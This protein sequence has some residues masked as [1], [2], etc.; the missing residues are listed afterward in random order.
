MRSCIT[1]WRSTLPRRAPGSFRDL[2][3]DLERQA[4][5]G[6]VRKALVRFC[7]DFPPQAVY[8]ERVPLDEYLLGTTQGVTNREMVLEE[9]LLLWLANVNP[10]FSPFREL[11]D[12]GALAQETAY[13]ELMAAA[14]EF[15]SR[16]PPFGPDGQSLVDMLRAPALALPDSLSG[17][18][19]YI[20]E[21]WGLLLGRVPDRLLSGLDLIREE[22][23]TFFPGPGPPRFL[24]RRR[25]QAGGAEKTG[26][27]PPDRDWMPRLVLMAKN[28]YVWLDQLSAR[29]TAA[30]SPPWTRSRTRN[31]TSWPPGASPACG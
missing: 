30:P 19:Q 9:M 4:G 26:A 15:F 29:R 28:I 27:L 10:A 5:P 3:A 11:F 14:G 7:R 23:K 21:H 1:W 22:E 17:Q 18:L 8:Q 25:E 16:Q 24:S 13:R 31:W 6:A 12:D 2:L 20:R